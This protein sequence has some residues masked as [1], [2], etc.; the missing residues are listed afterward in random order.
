MHVAVDQPRQ[1]EIAADVERWR[2]VRQGRRRAFA[3][4]RDLSV[5]DADIDKATIGEAAIGQ[6]YVDRR[7]GLIPREPLAVC[8][9]PLKARNDRSITTG[10]SLRAM[11]TRRERRSPSGHAA[12]CRGGC[13]RCCT[14][15][16][17]TGVSA[18]ATL[19]MPLTRNNASPWRWSS[20]V[21]PDAEPRP[22]DRLVE[23]ERQSADIVGVAVMIVGRM[24]SIAKAIRPLPVLRAV[25][26]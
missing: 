4:N 1:D 22:I 8:G 26:G 16:T 21:K 13:T 12:R 19:R 2:A 24:A 15:C 7:H 25:T 6:E 5:G 17:A 14:A 18:S 9:T 10:S 20:I 3:D 23:A 11:K